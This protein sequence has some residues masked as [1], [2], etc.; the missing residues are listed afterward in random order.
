MATQK[1]K[2]TQAERAAKGRRNAEFEIIFVNGK[3]KR[4]RRP[5]VIDGMSAEELI[6]ANADPIWLHQNEMWEWMEPEPVEN[7]EESVPGEPHDEI[8]L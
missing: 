5:G 6:R 7:R 3:Q 1:R 2:L 4:V 8:P